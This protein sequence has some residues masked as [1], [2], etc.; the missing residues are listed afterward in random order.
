MNKQASLEE[1]RFV[2]I[3]FDWRQNLQKGPVEPVLLCISVVTI[4]DR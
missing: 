2:Q 3:A 1:V 4:T